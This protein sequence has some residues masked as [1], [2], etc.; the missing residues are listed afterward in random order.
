ML[1]SLMNHSMKQVAKSSS[2]RAQQILNSHQILS[3]SAA[4]PSLSQQKQS[5]TGPNADVF[6]RQNHQAL[7]R[8][9]IL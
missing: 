7:Q 9:Q 2:A 6:S 3:T 8:H 5:L 1:L 4:K